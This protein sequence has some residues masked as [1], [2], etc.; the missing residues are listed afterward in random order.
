M[1]AADADIPELHKKTLAETHA[2]LA[3]TTRDLHTLNAALPAKKHRGVMDKTDNLN[4]DIGRIAKKFAI[5]HRLWIISSLFLIKNNPDVNLRSASRWES[6]AAKHDAILTELF[7]AMPEPL[8]KEMAK[9]KSFSSVFTSTLNQERSNM[10]HA[11]KEASALIFAPLKVPDA[12][13]FASPACKRDDAEMKQLSIYKGE[14]HRLAPIV[15]ADPNQMTP[16]GFL[17]SVVLLNVLCLLLFGRN[18]LN[19]EK[20]CGGPKA[21]GQIHSIHSMTE[22]LIALAMIFVCYLLSP[23]PELQIVG[24]E[25]KIPYEADYDF[26]LEHL[27]KRSKWAIDTV[28]WFNMELFGSKQQTSVAAEPRAPPAPTFW[29]T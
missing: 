8:H 26:Y 13:I 16:D 23:D 19:K 9:Y 21:R 7:M 11:I 29:T 18:A 27:F 12:T 6:P 2:E 24:S 25:T 3:I 4:E 5:L 14:Y 10:L 20:A 22:G 17:R 15:F 1:L 28:S